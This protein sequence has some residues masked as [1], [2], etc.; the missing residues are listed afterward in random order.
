VIAERSAIGAG[1]VAEGPLEFYD[2]AFEI[3]A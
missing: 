3:S 1:P 2:I